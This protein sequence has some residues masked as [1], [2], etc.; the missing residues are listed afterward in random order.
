[1]EIEEWEERARNYT[2]FNRSEE[3]KR[4]E[5]QS[6]TKNNIHNTIHHVIQS[7]TNRIAIEKLRMQHSTT[8]FNKS[9]K[10]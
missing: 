10:K 1:M 2:S 5:E 9:T 6:E 3:K 7:N 8:V 4:I